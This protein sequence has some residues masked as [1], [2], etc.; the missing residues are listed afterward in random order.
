MLQTVGMRLSHGDGQGE[1]NRISSVIVIN[2]VLIAGVLLVVIAFFW[3][4]PFR[5]GEITI[6]TPNGPSATFKV[7]DSNEISELIQ[8]GLKNEKTA[9]LLINSLLSVIENLPAGSK[10]SEK[11][12][13][14]AENRRPPFELS[15]VPVKLV[16]DS[17]VPQG[18]AGVCEKSAFAAKNIV[19]FV[20]DN[21]NKLLRHKPVQAFADARITFPCPDGREIVRLN[22]ND[23]LEF[24]LENALVKRAI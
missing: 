3:M 19:I 4:N 2:L 5:V 21:E 20:L 10:L 13:E 16:Y 8:K 7:A 9:A 11:L 1:G 18:L 23:M 24:K 22:S 15:S 12:L 17:D 14:L 6:A